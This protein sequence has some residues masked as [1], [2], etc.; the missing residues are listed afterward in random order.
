MQMLCNKSPRGHPSPRKPE[1]L[2]CPALVRGPS[3]ETLSHGQE[4]KRT[5]QTVPP[6]QVF[7]T[8]FTHLE[9]NGLHTCFVPCFIFTGLSKMLVSLSSHSTN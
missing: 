9:L 5:L 4:S 8:E 2:R 6:V 3:W 7:A 1:M